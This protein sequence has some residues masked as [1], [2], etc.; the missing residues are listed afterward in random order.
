MRQNPRFFLALIVLMLCSCSGNRIADFSEKSP[1]FN[2]E[3]FFLGKTKAYGV[4]YDWRERLSRRFV[5]EIVGTKKGELL[6]LDENFLFDDGETDQRHWEISFLSERDLKGVSPDVL[7]EAQG[8]RA[9]NALHWKYDLNLKTKDGRTPVHFDDWM[10][11]VDED[12][13][14]NRAE[15]SKFGIGVGEVYLFI[16]KV[17][18]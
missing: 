11:L 3:K 9:G 8:E 10:F 18:Q 13:L 15:V 17:A 14:F 5:A 2:V 16:E 1:E 7:G 12:H 6:V 4:F